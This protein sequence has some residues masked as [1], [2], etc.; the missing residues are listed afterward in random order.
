MNRVRSPALRGTLL[1]AVPRLLNPIVRGL[2]AS[3]LH[4]PLSRWLL[5]LRWDSAEAGRRRTTPLSYVREGA[6]L[7]L[8]G[9]DRWSKDLAGGA[10]VTIRLGGRWYDADAV[11]VTDREESA[12]ILGRLFR[13]HPWF[14]ILSGIPEASSDGPD[15]HADARAL[16]RALKA[17]RVLVRVSRREFVR[18][19]RP[20]ALGGESLSGL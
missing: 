17:G 15:G 2:L 16:D 9:G 1:G 12:A 18:S 11:V 10:D 20:G 7:Y 8:T 3:R 6:F 5:L 14:R 13:V 4:W 19:E